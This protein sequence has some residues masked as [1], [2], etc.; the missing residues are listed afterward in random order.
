[1]N[2]FLWHLYCRD[3]DGEFTTRRRICQPRLFT[4][5]CEGMEFRAGTFCGSAPLPLLYSDWR[6]NEIRHALAALRE[7][8]E[9]LVIN[10]MNFPLTNNDSQFLDKAL[11]RGAIT[12]TYG[13]GDVR[14]VYSPLDCLKIARDN[15]DKQV[16]FF[17]VGFETTAPANAMAVYQ[18]HQQ[19]V[20]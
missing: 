15:P 19:S 14:V 18:A 3:S 11:S 1:M 7:R 9:R 6:P 20:Q 13:G 8:G 5:P 2:R 4:R 12:I 17:A 16:V 10:I